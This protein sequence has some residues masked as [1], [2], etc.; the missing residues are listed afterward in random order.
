MNTR[1][2]GLAGRPVLVAEA[3]KA[4]LTEALSPLW[5]AVLQ[6]IQ[7]QPGVADPEE[8]LFLIQ[9]DRVRVV[10]AARPPVP[11][12]ELVT[13]SYG[14]F[15][16]EGAVLADA[17]RAYL[18]ASLASLGL[19]AADRAVQ[20]ARAFGGRGGFLLAFQ[21]ATGVS[22]LVLAAEGQDLSEALCV[23][24]MGALKRAPTLH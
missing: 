8:V 17:V 18:G 14:V 4:A 23:G 13:L 11:G 10:T 20:L 16:H 3:V 9:P 22:R 19:D 21:A 15:P 1:T 2:E 6:L 7:A 24:E 5:G 12:V